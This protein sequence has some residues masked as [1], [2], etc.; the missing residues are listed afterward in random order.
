MSEI[1]GQDEARR[2]LEEL[3][4][5][6]A[7][8]SEC[9]ATAYLHGAIIDQQFAEERMAKA[10]VEILAALRA[11]SLDR[12]AE[13]MRERCAKVCEVEAAACLSDIAYVSA[14]FP[15]MPPDERGDNLAH[16]RASSLLDAAAD[17]R[18]LPVAEAPSALAQ[19][20]KGEGEGG[21]ADG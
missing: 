3:L 20:A 14:Q 6:H 2:A 5:E 4:D 7:N 17:I 13:E 8:A 18:A 10:R 19:Q 9:A 15:D 21:G 11:P 1:T 16:A 12:G